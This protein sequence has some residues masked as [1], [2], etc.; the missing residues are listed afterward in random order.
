MEAVLQCSA[1]F[2]T[3][4]MHFFMLWHLSAHAH[5]AEDFFL[6]CLHL[7]YAW[8]TFTYV[9]TSGD[10]IYRMRWALDREVGN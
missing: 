8:R 10:L 9:Y 7:L 4:H 3:K 6:I 1:L 5:L 2:I